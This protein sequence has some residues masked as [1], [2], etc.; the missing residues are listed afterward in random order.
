M[1][2]EYFIAKRLVTAKE[3]NNRL[4]RPIIRLAILAIAL[5]IAVMLISVA[6][7]K[8]FKKDIA[9]KVIGFGAHIQITAF[10]D[11]NSFE[12]KAISKNQDFYPSIEKE[13]GVQ[14]IQQ[15]ATKAGIIKTKEEIHGVI[16][17]GVGSDFDASF[18]KS[19]LLEGKVP[20]YNDSITSSSVLISK[21]IVD[22]L[23][24]HLNEDLIIFFVQ[25]P[26]RVRKFN[27]EGI[28]AT[29][30]EE[31]DNLYV[32][33]DIRHIQ[34]L[35][36]WGVDSVGG[37]EININDFDELDAQTE[38]IYEKIAFNLDAQNTKQLNPQIF[39][40]LKLQD[41]NVN[42]IIILMLIVALINITTAL[43]ILI[44]E[45]TKLI[46]ILKAIGQINWSI[47]KVFLYNASY[48]IVK[49]LFWGN[50]I[51]ISLTLIQKHFQILSLNPATYYMKFVP[52]HLPFTDLLL[53]NFGVMFI[54]IF[55]LIIPTFLIT[56]ITAIK[57][58]RFE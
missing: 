5:S 50:L 32:F 20:I 31:F 27:I 55:M 33:A 57:A 8:G 40:W 52:I 14:H 45:H 39:D 11:N 26:P 9:D 19:N 12:T 46:G 56:K 53:L 25:D 35:N 48:L 3:G 36:S 43:L 22:M 41:I 18:L 29:E 13:G 23:K 4:S 58:I 37:F 51:G 34:N 17:K 47:R 1:N 15:F 16:L 10:S 42:V 28:Y 7:V 6:V 44:L 54:C 38:K 49:G 30:L 21:K 24:L 2:V